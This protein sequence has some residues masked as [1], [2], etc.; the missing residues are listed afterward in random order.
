[1][2][3]MAALWPE[4]GKVGEAPTALFVGPWGAMEVAAVACVSAVIT[5]IVAR[6]TAAVTTVCIEAGNG[7][8]TVSVA[9]MV[10]QVVV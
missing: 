2:K 4:L 7:R 8:S 9:E 5:S 10:W 1:M 3:E 6:T